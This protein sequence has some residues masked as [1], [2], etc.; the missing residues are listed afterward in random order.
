MSKRVAAQQLSSSSRR[1][2]LAGGGL[3]RLLRMSNAISA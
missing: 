1:R 3:S 2:V